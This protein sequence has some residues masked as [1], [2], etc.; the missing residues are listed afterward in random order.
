MSNDS[1]RKFKILI[2]VFIHVKVSPD[3]H[4][5]QFSDDVNFFCQCRGLTE[6]ITK[7]FKTL[8]SLVLSH[9]KHSAS[10][11]VLYGIKTLLLVF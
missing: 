10:C 5:L 9:I 1:L 7:L 6:T 4:K 8:T 2:S 11:L 3:F